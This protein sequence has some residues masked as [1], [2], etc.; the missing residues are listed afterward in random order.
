MNNKVRL[1]IFFV[2]LMLFS[3]LQ[4]GITTLPLILN[5]LIVLFVLKKQTWVLFVALMV[6]F[7]LDAFL[8]RT[9]G[10]SSLL[11]MIILLFIAFY[12]R[13]FEIATLPFVLLS[14]FGASAFYLGVFGAKNILLQTGAS[15]AI[16]GLLFLIFRPLLKPQV[17]KD[18]I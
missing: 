12:E 7:L 18:S 13:K 14:S 4:A 17:K 16:A 9:L 11:F 10:E 1:P 8:L 6:G 2:F 5:V 15:V 3:F